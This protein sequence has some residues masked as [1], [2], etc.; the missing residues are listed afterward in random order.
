MS[1]VTLDMTASRYGEAR[2]VNGGA[3][4]VEIVDH[5]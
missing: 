5:H 1:T 3:E 4:E 2:W